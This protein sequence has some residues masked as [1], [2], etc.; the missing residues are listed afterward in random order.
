MTIPRDKYSRSCL[1]VSINQPRFWRQSFDT[2]QSVYHKNKTIMLLKIISLLPEVSVRDSY[3]K[4]CWHCN[5]Q[6]TFYLQSSLFS[7]SARLKFILF[8]LY[9]LSQLEDEQIGDCHNILVNFLCGYW[10][11]IGYDS[12]RK[13]WIRWI[14]I[15]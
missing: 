10:I 15:F 6:L 1:P 11:F 7:L 8:L 5:F 2:F 13:C 9:V 3:W 4:M 14:F 12:C